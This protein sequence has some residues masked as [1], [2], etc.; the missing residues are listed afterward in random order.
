MS[1]RVDCYFY[2]Y[3]DD[4]KQKYEFDCSSCPYFVDSI[5]LHKDL[6][7][8]VTGKPYVPKQYF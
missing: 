8:K 6:I 7:E 4:E 3:L 2:D 1:K 5:K